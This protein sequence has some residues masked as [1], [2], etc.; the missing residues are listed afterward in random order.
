MR[1]NIDVDSGSHHVI[2]CS[3]ARLQ[4]LLAWKVLTYFSN[5]HVTF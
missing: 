1:I 5:A 2:G 3:L 4:R